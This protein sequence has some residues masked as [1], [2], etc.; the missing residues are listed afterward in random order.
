MRDKSG[1]L[2]SRDLNRRGKSR[3]LGKR[4]DL[5]RKEKTREINVEE[6]KR[7]GLSKTDEEE[8]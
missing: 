5:C 4:K 3:D 2:K 7:R 1:R 6:R 8:S